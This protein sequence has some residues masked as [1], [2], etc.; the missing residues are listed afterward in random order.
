LANAFQHAAARN[1]E[2]RIEYGGRGL[3]LR[4]VDD[5]RGYDVDALKDTVTQGHFGLAGLRERAHRIRAQLEVSSR[6]GA[7]STVELRVPASIA[8]ATDR[9]KDAPLSQ[10]LP[11]T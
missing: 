11:W 10:E 6:L 9:S 7:G 2:V 1:I 3:V 8:Y 5:G 4:V